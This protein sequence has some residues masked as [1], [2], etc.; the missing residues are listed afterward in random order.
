MALGSGRFGFLVLALVSMWGAQV[1]ATEPFFGPQDTFGTELGNGKRLFKNK[2]GNYK[3]VVHSGW[4]V[5]TVGGYT[6]I[7]A[8][9]VDSNN[10]RARVQITV[11]KAIDIQEFAD[12][13]RRFTNRIGWSLGMIG[14]YTSIQREAQVREDRCMFDAR[15]IKSPGEV[16]MISVD[17]GPNC[18][19]GSDFDRVKASLD[20]FTLLE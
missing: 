16:T 5:T 20:T 1:Q 14:K 8:P 6:E 17:G 11:T 9:S 13:A 4:D 19:E 10:G 3:M 7:V 15:I 2:D 12:L 18:Q